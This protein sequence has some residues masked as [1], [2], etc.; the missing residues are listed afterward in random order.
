[1]AVRTIRPVDIAPLEALLGT[2]PNLTPCLSTA[3]QSFSSDH[4]LQYAVVHA[5]YQYPTVELL[6]FLEDRIAGRKALE[7]CAGH[8]H[9]GKAL[10]IHSTDSYLHLRPDIRAMYEAMR[11][12]IIHPPARVEKLEAIEAV[13]KH[14]PEVVIGCWASH[15]S[16][17]TGG[18][19][20]HGVVEDELW[21][22][23][24]VQTYIH[25]GCVST[26]SRKPLLKLPH[27]ELFEPWL[28]SRAFKPSENVIYIWEKHR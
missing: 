25:V 2:P 3:L 14:E 15:L 9:I 11:Q 13:K 18:G 20:P 24:S 1:M 16:D 8:G 23:P 22:Q 7:I 27:E 19:S 21:A 5:V 28:V 10:G 26:H 6:G 17:A 4:I 12:P